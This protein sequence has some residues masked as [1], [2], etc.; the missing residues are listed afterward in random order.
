MLA[1]FWEAQTAALRIPK[2]GMAV[3]HDVGNI[4][5]IHPANKQEVGRR[6]ALLALKNDYGKKDLVANG[7]GFSEMK[8][9]GAAVLLKMKNTGSGLASRD[10]QPLTWFEIYDSEQGWLPA[11]A[12]ITGADLIRVT[13]DGVKEALAARFAWNK[14][15][16]P[17][18]MNKEGLPAWPFR[19]GDA[20]KP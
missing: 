10:G 8:S 20:P 16:E 15:A 6:L 18:L 1:N 12:E 2:T 17:N 3:I 14:I 5:D 7:P 9:D 19:T 13:G 4:N 11:K